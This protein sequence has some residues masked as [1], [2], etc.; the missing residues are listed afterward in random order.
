MLR[1]TVVVLFA[2]FYPQAS[3]AAPPKDL[4]GKSVVITWTESREQRPV[5]ETAWRQVKRVNETRSAQ[6]G[7]A[8]CSIRAGNVFAN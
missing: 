2:L 7:G 6:V 5:G 8:S 3:Y 1:L 4:F